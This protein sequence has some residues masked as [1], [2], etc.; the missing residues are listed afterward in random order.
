MESECSK[1]VWW[2]V[3]IEVFMDNQSL[4]VIVLR[5]WMWRKYSVSYLVLYGFFFKSHFRK[6][7]TP[8]LLRAIRSTLVHFPSICVTVPKFSL[9]NRV[10]KELVSLMLLLL[11]VFQKSSSYK[12]FFWWEQRLCSSG[13]GWSC[14]FS[15]IS[16]LISF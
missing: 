13:L 16:F 12:G 1:F 4:F 2:K 3:F 6:K 5:N 15:G 7:S 8:K 14:I 10:P 11:S 9:H